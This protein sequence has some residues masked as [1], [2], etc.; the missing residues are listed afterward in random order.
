MYQFLS[1]AKL[2]LFLYITGQR[3]DGYHLLQTWYQFLNYSDILILIPRKDNKI[4]LLTPLENI[5]NKNNLI[6]RAALLLEKFCN[7]KKIINAPYGMDIKINKRLPTGSGLGG[8]SSNAATI[9]VALNE[10]WNCNLNNNQLIQLGIQLG[11]DIPFFICGHTAFAEGIGEKLTFINAPEK[12]YLVAYPN[13]NISTK[14]IFNDKE[15]TRNTPIRKFNE[16]LSIPYKNDCELIVRKRFYK[17]EQLIFWLLR[18]APSRLTGT[19]SCVFSEFD[20]QEAAYKVLHQFPVSI[21]GFIS[22]GVNISPLYQCK[23]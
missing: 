20:S 16:L 17:V 11:A 18:Y 14:T 23:F 12:W 15:L 4:Q 3:K 2:N 22:Q 1:P 10:L 8:G 21:H 5:S 19:G 6:I 7:K 13:I 9:L